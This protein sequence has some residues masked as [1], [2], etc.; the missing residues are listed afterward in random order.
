MAEMPPMD[1]SIGAAANLASGSK[2][3]PQACRWGD[4]T[5]YQPF[6]EW[7]SAWDAPWTCCHPAHSG[8]LETVDTCTTCPDWRPA[9]SKGSLSSRES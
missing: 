9:S 4:A 8:P 5:L 2:R 6:P 3:T 1:R 7:L